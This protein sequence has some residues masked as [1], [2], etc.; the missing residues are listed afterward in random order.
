MRSHLVQFI[1]TYKPDVILG[2]ESHLDRSINSSEIFPPVYLSP[3]PNRNDRDYGLTG[4]VLIAVHSNIISMER[5]SPADCEI[6]WT[7]LS[8]SN[9]EILFG[10]FY[11]QPGSTV[12]VM[13]QLK[14][15][16]CNPRELAG[17]DGSHVH[18]NSWWR[19]QPPRC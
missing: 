4:K 8:H 18:C 6:V 11:R 5:L 10:S 7:K 17:V 15:S 2:C 16:M 9:G 12:H 13:E 1:E 14:L 3:P 19:L